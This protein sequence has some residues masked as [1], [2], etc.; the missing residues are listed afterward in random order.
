M[1]TLLIFLFVIVAILMT[2]AILLQSSK[3]GGLA[4]SFGGMGGGGSV[5]GP[6]GAANFLQKAT[7]ILA[8]LY[9]VL[10]LIIGLVGRPTQETRSIIR[11]E[12]QKEQQAV[13]LPVAPIQ[14]EESNQ[15]P[16]EN[17]QPQN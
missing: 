2:I 7:T 6:R 10:C 4:A 14:G 1:Y 13:P 12:L 8:A 16:A 5:F 17:P 9:L 11:Q 3:G 15:Q